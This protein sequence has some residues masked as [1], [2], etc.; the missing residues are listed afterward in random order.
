M[1]P[2]DAPTLEGF[3]SLTV[4]LASG[5]TF[6]ILTLPSM[7]SGA[8]LASVSGRI[9]MSSAAFFTAGPLRSDAVVPLSSALPSGMSVYLHVR[10]PA[11]T[12]NGET[13][14]TPPVDYFGRPDDG[15]GADDAARATLDA[16]P[17][18]ARLRGGGGGGGYFALGS[19]ERDARESA[20]E[21]GGRGGGGGGPLSSQLTAVERWSRLT[22][23]LANERT[24]LA[25]IRTTTPAFCFLQRTTARQLA[26]SKN[27]MYVGWGIVQAQTLE[28]GI[29][30]PLKVP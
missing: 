8:I 25:W 23:E 1:L 13:R 3:R 20:L 2:H 7:E 5:D 26:D 18:D 12:T 24:L 14:P 6:E 10:K 9:G 17:L 28:S 22:T 29:H 19:D 27:P 4:V 16:M 15:D 30:L 21:R 11:H